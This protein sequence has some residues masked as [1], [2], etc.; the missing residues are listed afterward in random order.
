MKI[1][2][3][4]FLGLMVPWYL[5]TIWRSKYLH[6]QGCQQQSLLR[7]FAQESVNLWVCPLYSSPKASSIAVHV[8]K[9]DSELADCRC[10]SGRWEKLAQEVWEI[11]SFHTWWTLIFSAIGSELGKEQCRRRRRRRRR[12]DDA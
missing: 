6:C 7:I 5:Q 3:D 10:I 4:N 11:V 2:G 9:E 12:S 8:V 1:L